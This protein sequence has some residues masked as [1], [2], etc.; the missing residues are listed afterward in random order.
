[1]SGLQVIHSGGTG[2]AQG[3]RHL[4]QSAENVGIILLEA[5]DPRQP[6]QGPGGLVAVQDPKIRQAQ[7]QLPPGARPV[8]EHQAGDGQ[9]DRQTDRQCPQ[10]PP[11]APQG[12]LTHQWAG[13]FMGLRERFSGVA[14][15]EKMLG[16]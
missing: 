3:D 6:C 15:T 13:Q 4:L 12:H 14:G 8:G 2:R 7:G 16:L 10:E 9:T 11:Q 1:M 5:P